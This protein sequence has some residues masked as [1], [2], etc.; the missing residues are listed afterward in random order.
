MLAAHS[1]TL[2]VVPSTFRDARSLRFRAARWFLDHVLDLTALELQRTE[3]DR[4]GLTL[5]RTSASL[6]PDGFA[7]SAQAV[8]VSSR[9]SVR[10][11]T[12]LAAKSCRVT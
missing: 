3:V 10:V 11:F 8:D 12:E 7:V 5:R 2:S 1:G 9:D 6:E 4:Q